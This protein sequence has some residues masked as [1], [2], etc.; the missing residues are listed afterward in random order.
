MT[1]E[2]T[3][4]GMPS[5]WNA[6][7]T[8]GLITAIV[9]SIIGLASAYLTIGGSTGAGQGLGISACLVSSIAGVIANRLYAK[10]FNLTYPI[11]KGALLGFLAGLVTLN[12]GT[13]ISLFWTEI[14][15]TGMNDA[16]NDALIQST[17]ANL[18]T[19]GFT[20]DQIDQALSLS[21]EP[22]SMIYILVQIGIGFVSLSI[23]NVISGIISAKIFAKEEE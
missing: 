12:V 17:I 11:G 21:L 15:D 13:A 16:L 1:T 20:Q 22:G 14:I 19:Q 4:H 5:Y 23:I 9:Y 8:A 2:T 10:G 3:H 18:E 7:I 6:V